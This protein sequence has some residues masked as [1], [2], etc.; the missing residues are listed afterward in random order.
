M[1]TLVHMD[2]NAHIAVAAIAKMK[3][4]ELMEIIQYAKGEC[5][6]NFYVHTNY[7][8]IQPA[9]NWNYKTY[10]LMIL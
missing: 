5:D 2:Q 6:L 1:T 4:A 8:N 3:T 10:T 9:C 7:D